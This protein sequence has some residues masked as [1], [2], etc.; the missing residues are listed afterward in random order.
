MF[1]KQPGNKTGAAGSKKK[2]TESD[3]RTYS[4]STSSRKLAA[5]SPEL[6]KHGMH[7]PSIHEHDLSVFADEVWNVCN[8]RNILNESIQNKCIDVGNVYD[9]VDESRH[10]LLA[11]LC[12]EFGNLQEHKIRGY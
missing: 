10:S 2:K 5:S 8:Q 6:K 4:N 3:E 11:E 7:E 1:R 12:G 9:F